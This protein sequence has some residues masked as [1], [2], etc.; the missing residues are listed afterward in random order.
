MGNLQRLS[1]GVF[2]SSSVVLKEHVS[3]HS[4]VRE[5]CQLAGCLFDDSLSAPHTPGLDGYR[6]LPRVHSYVKLPRRVATQERSTAIGCRPYIP[7]ECA[8]C[9]EVHGL[10]TR[11]D[12]LMAT[13]R[14][15]Q[16]LRN[17]T[18]VRW[19]SWFNS[20]KTT[21]RPPLNV[22]A[23]RSQSGGAGLREALWAAFEI[24]RGEGRVKV[25]RRT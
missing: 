18:L 23:E 1:I 6:D 8:T 21:P 24:Q 20:P 5:G 16:K 3:N 22:R 17:L 9:W 25:W 11:E 15:A 2:L 19:S 7:A 12:E 13:M 10:R 4:L 14:L